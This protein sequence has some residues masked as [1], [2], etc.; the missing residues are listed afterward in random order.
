LRQ[1]DIQNAFLHGF[2][3]EVYM[4][5]PLGYE[6]KIKFNYVCKLVKA[7]CALK[8]SPR[9]WYSRLSSKLKNLGFVPSKVNKSLFLFNKGGVTIFVLIYVD[10]IIVGSSTHSA[11]QG[12]LR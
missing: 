3:E 5:Q 11:T 6:D 4:K 2:L 1:L 12:L 7:L 10:D 8:Q 9:V